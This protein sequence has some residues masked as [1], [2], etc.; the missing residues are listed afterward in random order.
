M[1]HGLSN[2]SE[3]Q[4]KSNLAELFRLLVKCHV[5]EEGFSRLS[6]FAWRTFPLR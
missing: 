5:T 1:S 2:E 6:Q 3:T 4:Q